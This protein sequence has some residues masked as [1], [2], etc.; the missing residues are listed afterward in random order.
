[1]TATTPHS[2]TSHKRPN[3]MLIWL[4]LFVLTVAEVSL[5]FELPLSRNI[6]LL[7]LLFL[8]VWK[9]LLVALFFMHLK[10]ERWRLRIIFIIPLPLAIILVTA[11]VMEK[12]FK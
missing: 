2:D 6:K 9:A 10:F 5:A 7:L 1:M 8:A 11:G 12:V 4:Y 3:Y